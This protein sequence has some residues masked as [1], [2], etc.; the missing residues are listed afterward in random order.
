MKN[1]TK[2]VVAIEALFFGA[3]YFAHAQVTVPIAD[4]SKQ[5]IFRYGEIAFIEDTSAKVTFDQVRSG[6]L[7]NKFQYSTAATPVTWDPGSAY[8]YRLNIK[9]NPA[10]KN[11][12]MLEFFDQTIDSITVYSPDKNGRYRSVLLGSNRPFTARFFQHKNL[13]LT[14]DNTTDNSA[15]YYVR[16]RSHQS[17]NVIIVLRTVKWFFSY[18]LEEYFLFGVFYG[19][20]L[21]FGLYNLIMFVAIGQ[22]QYLYYIAYNISI[23]LYEMCADGIAFQYIWPSSP[24]WNHYAYG[25]A[26]FSAS[27]FAVLFAQSLLNV[28]AR[29]PRLNKILLSIIAGRCVFFLLCIFV[30]KNWFTYK[31][32]E[33][34]P[35]TVALVTG[36]YILLQ[37][38][39]PA[40]FFVIG[41]TF[42]LLGFVV[43]AMIALNLWWLPVTA[44]DYYAL[45]FCFIL[46]MFFVSFA[47]G[48]KVRVLRIQKKN[49]QQRIIRE[50]RENAQL[51]D[52]LTKKL[53][54]QVHERTVQL[55]QKAVII[56]Q[57]NLELT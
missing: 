10:S 46:E 42:L 23:G 24:T 49:A 7:Q 6:K 25:I 20:I 31:I 57:Q 21:V 14:L 40:R 36:W 52:S 37:G 27:I 28:K 26:L 17:V 32:I 38:Y 55:V 29:A 19:M 8:W 1:V 30:N 54:E 39:R 45:S 35:L 33:I 56:E 47:I 11:E 9:H 2:I 34:V 3:I 12:W 48:D 15:T 18:A 50:L 4:T 22:R 43:K 51:K 44:F 53:E 41:Y 13:S 16:I 5:H